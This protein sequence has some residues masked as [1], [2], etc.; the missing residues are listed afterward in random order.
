MK[1]KQR[2]LLTR[3][4]Y[5]P[6]RMGGI[7]VP[8]LG[9][10]TLAA[11]LRRDRSSEVDLK[12]L[13]TGINKLT[14]SEV[15]RIIRE[16]EPDVLGLSALSLE[17]AE[18]HKITAAAKQN[19]P[20]IKVV[21]GGPHATTF[22]DHVLLDSN[23]DYAVVGE[24]E[25]TFVELLDVLRDGS[26]ASEILG[27]ASRRDG[28]LYFAGHR[29]FEEDLD[30]IPIPAWDLI[31]IPPYSKAMSMNGFIAEKPYAGLFTSRACPYRCIYCHRIFGKKFRAQSTERVLEEIELLHHKF[32]VRELHIYDDIFNF[33]HRRVMAITEGVLERGIDM[34]FAFPNGIRGD[35]MTREMIKTLVRAGAYSITYAVETASS[36]LQKLINKN[37]NLD[38]VF[39]CIEWTFEEGAIPCG[40]F[41]LGFP[42]ETLEEMESTLKFA[43]RSKMLKALFFC[44]VPFPQTE[45]Y[46]LVQ[47]T[48]PDHDFSYDFS[49]GMYYWS[50]K[51]FYSE[52]SGIDVEAIQARAWKTFYTDPWRV[53]NI[54]KR[55][56]K[57]SSFMRG[58]SRGILTMMGLGRREDSVEVGAPVSDG[59]CKP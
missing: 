15:A 53:W 12:V 25:V 19:D 24:G 35:I 45:L 34:K 39:E 17:T 50:Q 22:H 44:V 14:V 6:G 8:P 59:S 33:N 30:S 20:G 36:R 48:Y 23:V 32:G 13:D 27:V 37:L 43:C 1:R 18:L 47:E 54:I 2:V 7:I 4:S 3:T 31:D 51:P 42:T 56:P 5:L 9:I 29:P 16:Y 28:Q 46:R 26:D 41:M 21:I 40:F 10:L 52:V 58:I 11:V 49:P 57:N 38:K 55:F